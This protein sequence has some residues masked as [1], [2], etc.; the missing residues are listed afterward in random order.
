[1]TKNC[2]PSST[3]SHVCAEASF[4]PGSN[5]RHRTPRFLSA[6]F[7]HI[8]GIYVA[9]KSNSR[10]LQS[11]Y[12][13][14]NKLGLLYKMAKL[15]VCC[16]TLTVLASFVSISLADPLPSGNDQFRFSKYITLF[17]LKKCLIT[18]EL[19]DSEQLDSSEYSLFAQKPCWVLKSKVFGQKSTVVK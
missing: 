19:G 10:L 8:K 17:I 14:Q 16:L 2:P 4:Y 3:L 12:T 9:S 5:V 11:Y 18:D 7:D 13:V 1:M 15:I 6:G